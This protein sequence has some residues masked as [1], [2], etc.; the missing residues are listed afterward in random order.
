MLIRLMTPLAL[1]A[2]V[3]L[4]LSNNVNIHCDQDVTVREFIQ[5]HL[6]VPAAHV[7]PASYK[8]SAKKYGVFPAAMYLELHVQADLVGVSLVIGNCVLTFLVSMRI[9]P[10]K[11]FRLA[12]RSLLRSV[13]STLMIANF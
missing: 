11:P 4:R 7:I 5:A 8:S 9:G 3:R 13:N 6:D 1:R 12:R 10:V 2:D